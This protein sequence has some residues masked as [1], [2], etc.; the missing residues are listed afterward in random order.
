M[1]TA[2]PRGYGDRTSRPGGDEHVGSTALTGTLER[3]KPRLMVCGHIHESYGSYTLG[4]TEVIN[5][6]L[7]DERYQPLHPVVELVL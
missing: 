1:P 4:R 5:V 7:V 3:V 2:P 6:S